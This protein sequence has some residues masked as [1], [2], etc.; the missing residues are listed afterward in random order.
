MDSDGTHTDTRRWFVREP[1]L[2][3]F[4]IM[5]GCLSFCT[6]PTQLGTSQYV[7]ELAV[8]ELGGTPA[9]NQVQKRGAQIQSIMD[10]I[11]LA[12]VLPMLS[13]YGALAD[14]RGR[15][16]IMRIAA[17]AFFLSG[18]M[19][20]AT[21]VVGEPGSWLK[22]SVLYGASVVEGLG[23]SAR[24]LII[25]S[26]A[27]L[28]DHTLPYERAE[29][30]AY[31]NIIYTFGQMA[32]PLVLGYVAK[33]TTNIFMLTVCMSLTVVL[34]VMLFGMEEQKSHADV[35]MPPLRQLFNPL[36]ALPTLFPFLRR[37]ASPPTKSTR[38]QR[39]FVF[40]MFG[41]GLMM[42]VSD[43]LWNRNRTLY[44]AHEFGWRTFQNGIYTAVMTGTSVASI[45]L[46]APL[47]SRWIEHR[48]KAPAKE[49]E[50][51]VVPDAET[52]PLLGS[53]NALAPSDND[54]GKS[55]AID[56]QSVEFL[57]PVI[58]GLANCASYGVMAI[59]RSSPLFTTVAA[60]RPLMSFS[61]PFLVSLQ[62]RCVP[63]TEMG[64]YFAASSLL[65]G[66]L[67][68][69]ETILTQAIYRATIDTMPNAILMIES[70]FGLLTA[71]TAI[72][73]MLW[74]RRVN[75]QW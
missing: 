58:P 19:I 55:P 3:F 15:L 67:G 43:G 45:A 18:V 38:T 65:T 64:N 68:I 34:I 70:A 46:I 23:G 25:A 69:V 24:V 40:Y 9:D 72:A 37:D 4:L 47:V 50:I 62:T 21:S 11:S 2:I 29:V 8:G 74:V 36:H 63:T 28:V 57:F 39:L 75:A 1:H 35:A 49:E 41:V 56:M 66:L 26:T 14:V 20:V 33:L 16:L 73:V 27:Y 31:A 13:F 17:C 53:A 42:T 48:R 32:G 30:L 22:M 59:T 52:Q 51:V 54:T 71:A 44:T 61:Q 60:L 6:T 7:L 10:T 5:T 12:C